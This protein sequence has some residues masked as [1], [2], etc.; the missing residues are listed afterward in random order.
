MV[1][2]ASLLFAAVWFSLQWVLEPSRVLEPIIALVSAL[3]A[4]VG[5]LRLRRTEA[6]KRYHSRSTESINTHAANKARQ[7]SL[8]FE[9]N[10]WPNIVK[11]ILKWGQVLEFNRLTELFHDGIRIKSPEVYEEFLSGID[12]TNIFELFFR[13]YISRE[14]FPTAKGVQLAN[15]LR[16]IGEV[17]KSSDGWINSKEAANKLWRAINSFRATRTIVR[18]PHAASDIGFVFLVLLDR[19]PETQRR[20]IIRY[21]ENE[22]VGVLNDINRASDPNVVNGLQKHIRELSM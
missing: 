20:E 11:R 16:V 6:V 4:A 17:I 22:G 14:S 7:E 8:R 3:L 5:Y 15:D 10:T 12:R 13:A 21:F 2:E 19:L 9:K 18:N 1:V